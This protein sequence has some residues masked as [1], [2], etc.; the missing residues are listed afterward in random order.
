LRAAEERVPALEVVLLDPDH[1][2]GLRDVAHVDVHETVDRSGHEISAGQKHLDEYSTADRL[3]SG[4]A[5]RDGTTRITQ[6]MPG[7]EAAVEPEEF[8]EFDEFDPLDPS[9]SSPIVAWLASD[10]ADH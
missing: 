6:T 10:E 8:G 5:A 9:I 4:S 2:L 3:T 1:P 7:F